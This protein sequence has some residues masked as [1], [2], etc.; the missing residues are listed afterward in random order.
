[1]RIQHQSFSGK[2][3]FCGVRTQNKYY[4]SP[5]SKVLPHEN[6]YDDCPRARFYC[7]IFIIYFVLP[8]IFLIFGWKFLLVAILLEEIYFRHFWIK[9]SEKWFG[10]RDV[11]E[12][13]DSL[14]EKVGSSNRNYVRI[15]LSS[16]LKS[17]FTLR[18]RAFKAQSMVLEE[19]FD[20][21]DF[22]IEFLSKKSQ[23]LDGTDLQGIYRN[24]IKD[25]NEN[26]KKLEQI[27]SL[28]EK[29]E[30]NKNCVVES[31]RLLKSRILLL[32]TDGSDK[33]EIKIPDDLKS[34]HNVYERVTNSQL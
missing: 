33:E 34:L 6:I 5:N 31:I 21:I 14:L 23:T 12:D 1:M 15:L 32:E 17:L 7:I 9:E 10:L 22:K 3:I 26:R 27:Y 11:K 18:D 19:S 4:K 29:F 25:L 13:Y 20:E 8:T 24:Q 30:A 28:L 2:C 16:T